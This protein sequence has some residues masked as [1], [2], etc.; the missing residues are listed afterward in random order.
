MSLP[1]KVRRT[2]GTY[3]GHQNTRGR[4]ARHFQVELGSR[5]VLCY[6]PLSTVDVQQA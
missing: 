2:R 4:D 5:H 6:S 3:S 1:L